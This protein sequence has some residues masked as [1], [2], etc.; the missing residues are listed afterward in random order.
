MAM[1]TFAKKDSIKKR[2]LLFVIVV[3]G[4]GCVRGGKAIDRLLLD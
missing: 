1:Y 3:V 4:L 2:A